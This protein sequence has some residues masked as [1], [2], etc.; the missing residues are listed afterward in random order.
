MLIDERL[1]AFL[2]RNKARLSTITIIMQV[3]LGKNSEIKHLKERSNFVNDIIIAG[4]KRK[5]AKAQLQT[6]NY[7]VVRHK[8]II[9][10]N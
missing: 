3:E 6:Q 10:K 5:L 1:K 7:S 9:L 4:N 8:V 2:S